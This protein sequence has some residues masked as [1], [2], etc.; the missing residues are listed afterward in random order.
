MDRLRKTSWL[1]KEGEGRVEGAVGANGEKGKPRTVRYRAGDLY[2]VSPL[3]ATIVV[4]RKTDGSIPISPRKSC[5]ISACLS[6]TGRIRPRSGE[7]IRTKVSHEEAYQ[8]PRVLTDCFAVLSQTPLRPRIASN[9]ARRADLADCCNLA[10]F[11]NARESTT[12]LPRRL[13]HSRVRICLQSRQ[14]RYRVRPGLVEW[15]RSL[16]DADECVRKP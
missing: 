16:G 10:K 4:M 15:Q 9:A 2:E 8:V 1:P 5:A 13:P 12:I 3:F 11:R 14:A 7:A 6:S